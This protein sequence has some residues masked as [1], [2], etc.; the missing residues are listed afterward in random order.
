MIMLSKSI[1]EEVLAKCLVTGGDFAE[2]FE[3]NSISNS[4]TFLLSFQCILRRKNT[5][6]FKS[7]KI[8]TSL[9]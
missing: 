7:L 4:T 5:K 8:K 9:L 3:D 2:I 1:A 6:N